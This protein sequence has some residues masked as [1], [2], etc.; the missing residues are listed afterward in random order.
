MLIVCRI[1]GAG[2]VANPA[3]DSAARTKIKSYSKAAFGSLGQDQAHLVP[4][5]VYIQAG[6]YELIGS[7]FPSSVVPTE[8]VLARINRSR[9]MGGRQDRQ[10]PRRQARRVWGAGRA[11]REHQNG[12]TLGRAAHRKCYARAIRQGHSGLGR[13]RGSRRKKNRRVAGKAEDCIAGARR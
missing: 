6:N 3:V 8:S 2:A 5:V 11:R 1:I 7:L 10:K 12:A 13:K 9:P 4:S